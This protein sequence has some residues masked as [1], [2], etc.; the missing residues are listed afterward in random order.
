MTPSR[1]GVNVGYLISGRAFRLVRNIRH[2]K[3]DVMSFKAWSSASAVD[4]A[5]WQL[6]AQIADT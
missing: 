5:A 3:D 4:F 1:S 2:R 6:A